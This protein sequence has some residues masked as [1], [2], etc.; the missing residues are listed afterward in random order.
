MPSDNI[1]R[2][3]VLRAL[4]EL[5]TKLIHNLPGLLGNLILSNGAQEVPRISQAISAQGPKL[6]QFEACT[7]DFKDIATRGAVG[8][9][10]T[11]TQ[12][13]L[14]ND[15]LAGLDK[16]GSKLSLNIEGT[17]LWNNEELSIR[18]DKGLL[19]HA[20]VSNI[21]VGCDTLAQRRI[22]RASDGLQAGDKVHF[23]I[24]GNVKGVPC[25]LGGGDVN[26]GVQR[27][28]VGLGV[29][30]IWELGLEKLLAFVGISRY[31]QQW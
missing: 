2:T 27:Q 15:D 12:A 24:I 20:G 22:T 25:E 9:F 10:Y 1:E 7:P 14:D 4:E 17:L 26:A 6:R 23:L 31:S 28:E 18:V 19:L 29:L 5:A 11:E 21:D 13:T 3:V 16:Q 8:E 30:I